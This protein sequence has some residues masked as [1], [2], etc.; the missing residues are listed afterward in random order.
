MVRVASLQFS[1][2][3][4]P[5]TIQFALL[6]TGARRPARHPPRCRR[7]HGEIEEPADLFLIL[8][9]DIPVSDRLEFS[10][11]NNTEGLQMNQPI[12]FEN[13]L[14]CFVRMSKR[15]AVFDMYAR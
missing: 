2:D 12:E 3:P 6:D 9:F 13:T 14:K 7:Q 15:A 8:I 4:L 1:K 11:Q 5:N 10:A